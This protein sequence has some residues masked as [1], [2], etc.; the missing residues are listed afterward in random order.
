MA[1]DSPERMARLGVNFA[2]RYLA[3]YEG[4]RSGGA[5]TQSWKFAMDAAQEWW[6][7]VLQHLLLAMNAHINLD[8][9]IAAA[10]TSPGGELRR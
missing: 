5:G 7:I 2:N 8:L 1:F 6:P 3:A 10:G 9:G 4:Y